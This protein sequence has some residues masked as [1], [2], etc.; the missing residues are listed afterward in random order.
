MLNKIIYTILGFAIAF[1]FFPHGSDAPVKRQ[2]I[3]GVST[4][5]SELGLAT[6]PELAAAQTAPILT[7]KAAL[8][9]DLNSG[10]ILYSKNF[11]EKLPIASLTKLMTALV[12]LSRADLNQS[13]IITKADQTTV[14]S[15]I[16]LAIGEEI[17]IRDLLKALLIPSANDAALTLANHVG[18]SFPV[19]ADEMNQHAGKL[20]LTS[21]HFANPVGWDSDE[22]YSTT[23]DLIKITQEVLKHKELSDIIATKQTII[24]SVD[25]RFTHQLT[26]TNQLM[27]ENPEIIGVKTGFTSKALGNLVILDNHENQKVLTVVLGSQNR[28]DDTRQLLDWLFTVYKW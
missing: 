1:I 6:A 26:T 4:Q 3:S 9:F 18:G 15:T 23:L 25:G 10:T 22:N 27:L 20:G 19:F 7:A 14:G 24:G 11:D 16:G 12:V 21:T 17:R 28:E 13:V 2:T 5:L 8:A